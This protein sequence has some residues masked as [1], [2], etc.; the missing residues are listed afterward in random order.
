[1]NEDYL[2]TSELE[3]ESY[4]YCQNLNLQ[5]I[6][7][8]SIDWPKDSFCLLNFNV[9]SCRQNYSQF[10]SYLSYISYNFSVIVLTET[11]LSEGTDVGFDIEGYKSICLNRDARGGGIKAYVKE[12][13]K[14]DLLH[15][16]T[17]EYH[18]LEIIT[19]YLYKS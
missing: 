13:Y 5:E 16:F 12:K 19:S 11:W 14:I 10:L 15:D 4:I 8:N 3:D 9:R 18:V 2:N 7:N 1:M 17:F 6:Q